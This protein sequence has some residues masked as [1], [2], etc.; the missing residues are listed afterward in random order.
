MVRNLLAVVFVLGAAFADATE[1]EPT[2]NPIF[3]WLRS[4]SE[5][6]LE[7]MMECKQMPA[8]FKELYY[9]SDC[10]GTGDHRTLVVTEALL[11]AIKGLEHMDGPIADALKHSLVSEKV[12]AWAA[13]T[14]MSTAHDRVSKF[15]NQP[16]CTEKTTKFMHVFTPCYTSGLC[17]A[18]DSFLPRD[19]CKAL[20][21]KYIKD[22]MSTRLGSMCL[23]ED[24]HDAAPYFCSELKPDLMV[25]NF[26]CY[27][28]FQTPHMDNKTSCDPKCVKVWHDTEKK[29]PKCTE[30]L[31]RETQKLY[32]NMISLMHDL[33]ENAKDPNVRRGMDSLPKFIPAYEQSCGGDHEKTFI[34]TH[35]DWLDEAEVMG[36]H[37][38]LMKQEWYESFKSKCMALKAKYSTWPIFL[39]THSKAGGDVLV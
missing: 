30:A 24:R 5:D 6:A 25:S 26:E 29:L 19:K 2:S 22:T 18:M 3:D 16:K 14:F 9:D 7:T 31:T 15:C 4:H 23:Q 13:K 36:K 1:D 8:I 39:P 12:K 20:L 33:L 32:G 38:W 10:S 35:C 21:N 17:L 37:E 27:M 28:Q 11:F 34:H